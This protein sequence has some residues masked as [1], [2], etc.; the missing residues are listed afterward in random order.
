MMINNNYSL[1]QREA[2]SK[3]P[4][5]EI[6]QQANLISEPQLQ[7]ALLT[8]NA[9]DEIKEYHLRIGEILVLRGCIKQK[10]VDF[11]VDDFRGLLMSDKRRKIGFYL[12]LSG[13]LEE[14]QIKIILD[15]Q[16]KI[17]MKFGLIAVKKKWIKPKTIDFFL[18]CFQR[19]N[20]IDVPSQQ[21]STDL[22]S[23]LEKK[24]SNKSEDFT[25]NLSV[26]TQNKNHF[27]LDDD[28]LDD[29]E[30]DDDEPTLNISNNYPRS[31]DLPYKNTSFWRSL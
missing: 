27:E 10:T 9:L 22:R 29:D 1:A 2:L 21:L 19:S 30:L 20:I 13:L 7:L 16:K 4:L 28:E 18:R 6:L 11:F 25:Y 12:L 31:P 3:K 5:G 24:I 23:K 8:Q 14:E 26:L 15:E 17:P